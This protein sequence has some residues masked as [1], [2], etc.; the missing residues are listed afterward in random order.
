MLD[1]LFWFELGPFFIIF[2]NVFKMKIWRSHWLMVAQFCKLSRV[3]EKWYILK[4]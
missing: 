4:D 2:G 1:T 3:L